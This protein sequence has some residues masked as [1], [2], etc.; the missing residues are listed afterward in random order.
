MEN[1]KRE[2]IN[3]EQI[4]QQ[5]LLHKSQ[6]WKTLHGS[7][8]DFNRCLY[9]KHTQVDSQQTK[10]ENELDDKKSGSEKTS[11]NIDTTFNEILEQFDNLEFQMT[12]AEL[13]ST[14]NMRDIEYYSLK[15]K[16]RETQISKIKQEIESLSEELKT[17]EIIKKLKS[18]YEVTSKV[19]ATYEEEP[20]VILK[21]DEHKERL[22]KLETDY[23]YNTKMIE[24]RRKQLEVALVTLNDFQKS[25][26]DGT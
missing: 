16:D 14:N 21:I 19:I 23:K 9:N 20:T 7:I 24:L 1:G 10:I 15:T 11:A 22:G 3:E 8:A 17:N 4:I 6:V 12:K 5:R 13:A 2:N 26:E 18:K 25:I